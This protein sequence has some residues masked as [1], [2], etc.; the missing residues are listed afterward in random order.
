[1]PRAGTPVDPAPARPRQR[2]NAKAGAAGVCSK[3][4]KAHLRDPVL[5]RGH[6]RPKMSRIEDR[7]GRGLAH[8]QNDRGD[9]RNM[10]AVSS[11]AEDLNAPKAS[12]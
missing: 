1:M 8:L 3:G 2:E 12:L 10:V 11:A 5:S 6:Y 7:D 9:G 4:F